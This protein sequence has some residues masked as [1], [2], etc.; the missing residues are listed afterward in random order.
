MLKKIYLLMSNI[1]TDKRLLYSLS[2]KDFIRKFSG[3]Y[4]GIIW[5]FVQP[6]LT[7]IVYWAVFQFGF[8]SGD[9]GNIPYIL[10]FICGI[11]PWLFISESFSIASNSFI[12]Y[13]YLIKKVK[14]NINILPLVKIL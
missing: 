2:K 3:T 7:I 4:F 6:L 9:V 11:V 5:A 12:E 10:W 14:F 13:S 8:R 1:W